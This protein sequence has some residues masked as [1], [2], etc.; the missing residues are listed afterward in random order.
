[1]GEN[2]A[3][4]TE[5]TT[6][7]PNEEIELASFFFK[8][9]NPHITGV[10]HTEPRLFKHPVCERIKDRILT[11]YLY[12]VSWSQSPIESMAILVKFIYK[13]YVSSVIAIVLSSKMK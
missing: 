13:I 11:E 9:K 4:N 2:A 8:G 10:F 5:E 7:G 1:M 12:E 3:T 6:K